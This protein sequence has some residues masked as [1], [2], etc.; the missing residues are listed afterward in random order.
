[1]LI[2]LSIVFALTGCLPKTAG[3]EPPLP[4]VNIKAILPEDTPEDGTVYIVGNYSDW[5]FDNAA[6]SDVKTDDEGKKYAEFE[7]EISQFPLEYKYT[8]GP[9]WAYVEKDA[10]GA[11]IGNRVIE[12]E[13][14]GV[15]EDTVEK[16][17][18]IPES[19]EP[20]EPPSEEPTIVKIKANLPDETPDDATIYII[21]SYCNWNFNN[22]AT[23]DV[24][25]D[26]ERKKY[27][28]FELDFEDAEYPLEYKYTYGAS[29]DY[30]E[31]DENG[32]GLDGNRRIDVK[33][34]KDIQDVVLNW[35]GKDKIDYTDLQEEI[36]VTFVVNVPEGTEDDDGKIYMKGSFNDW[37]E[38][39]PLVKTQEGTY[40]GNVEVQSYTTLRFKFL[41][42][43]N[44]DNEE[45][46]GNN[47][48]AILSEDSTITCFVEKWKN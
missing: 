48:I 37:S 14:E 28:E 13:P 2:L 42:K 34:D 30:E 11:E 46:V 39:T 24:K 35:K 36:T 44:W 27:A 7:L 38:G 32:R 29:W 19:Q 41:R 31:L 4:V 17:K 18:D 1:M 21:G 6:T 10:E 22:A 25:T 23:S 47:R 43:D 15:I 40:T 16:W 8:V 5:G 12:S 3:Q 20:T 33:P 9:D 45:I 26:D